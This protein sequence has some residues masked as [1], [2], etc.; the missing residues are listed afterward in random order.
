MRVFFLSMLGCLGALGSQAQAFTPAEVA[1]WRQQAQ[2]VRITRDT[3]GVPHVSG[4]T[5]ADAVF[6][7]LYAQCED[8]FARVEDNYLEALGRRAEVEGESALYADLRARLFMDTT[9]A[10]AVYKQSPLWMKQL[11]DGFA[12]GTNYYLATHPTVQPKLLRRFQP[13]MPLL[14]S[15]GSIGGN[16]SVVP[17]ERIKAFYSQQKTTSWQRHPGLKSAQQLGLHRGVRGEVV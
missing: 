7:L 11:L 16:I 8:D 9:R 4:K 1:H 5:D 3:W 14:F 13:W 12:A 2:Q 15:E 10:I 17:V 6:G